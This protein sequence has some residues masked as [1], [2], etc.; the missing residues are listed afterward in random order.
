[1]TVYRPIV[2]RASVRRLLV[3]TQLVQVGLLLAIP[4]AILID[5]FLV[6]VILTI[7]PV[8][9]I[10][11]QFM[12]PAQNAALPRLVE[13]EELVDANSLFSIAYGG[14]NLLFNAVGGLLIG[15]LGT[16]ALF[17]INAT[18]F[19]GSALLFTTVRIPDAEPVN[20]TSD[21]R[22]D[23]TEPTGGADVETT[24]T[25]TPTL[26]SFKRFLDDLVDGIEIIRNSDLGFI[27]LG[28]TV[29]DFSLGI[30]TAVLPA[31]AAR[32]GGPEIYG[33]L[34]GAMGVGSVLGSI[35]SSPLQTIPFG[36]FTVIGFF[37]GAVA[38]VAAI[39]SPVVPATIVL[40]A[41]AWTPFGIMSVLL[42]ALVQSVVP[43][44][45]VGRVSSAATSFWSVML[46]IG[47]L[48]GVSLATCSVRISRWPA[49]R[50]RCASL[51]CTS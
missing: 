20:S 31:F 24:H 22:P 14:V 49:E 51:H 44:Y 19:L 1:M 50:S 16:I 46:P 12:Y 32:R 8:A 38:L 48:L 42:F 23:V 17:S 26:S 2:D 21:S 27:I 13:K 39:L 11:N 3:S 9:A 25:D 43:E 10:V 28:G 33:L 35:A 36:R 30:A 47:S 6:W 7:I 15:L 34:V 40:Y 4:L 37:A 45:L 5:Y 18:I 29:A 41:L